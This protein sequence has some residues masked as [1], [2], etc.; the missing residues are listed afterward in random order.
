MNKQTIRAFIITRSIP[1]A[2]GL[3]ALLR[4]ISQIDEIGIAGN[5][6]E[7]FEQ[8]E[9]RKPRIVLI[10]AVLAGSQPEELLEKIAFLSP[11]TQRVLL[12]EDVQDMKWMP[13]HAEAILIKGVSPS[14]VAGILTNLLFSKGDEHEHDDPNP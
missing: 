4:A 3:D 2:D 7:A 13:Q 11:E 8:I 14:A 1:L 5:M 12:V 9:R 6:Q 10:D